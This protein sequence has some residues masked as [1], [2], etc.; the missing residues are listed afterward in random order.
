MAIVIFGSALATT[1]T[2]RD[3]DYVFTGSP[4]EAEGIVRAWAAGRGLPAD[5]PLDDKPIRVAAVFQPPQ[6]ARFSSIREVL[7]NVE[8]PAPCGVQ[9]LYEILASP[10]EVVR[11]SYRAW[12]D[13]SSIL[14]LH[15]GDAEQFLSVLWDKSPTWRISMMPTEGPDVSRPD[16][17]KYCMGLLAL[18]SAVLHAPA[19]NDIWPQ[20]PGGRLLAALATGEQDPVNWEHGSP[21]AGIADGWSKGKSFRFHRNGKLQLGDATLAEGK[22]AARLDIKL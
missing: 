5:L 21:R 2:P 7:V 8:L 9:G 1:R 3:I 13:F 11:V 22:I 17:D 6:W 16:W 14:R 4:E 15:G 19:W 12:W 18:R 10:E 20:L